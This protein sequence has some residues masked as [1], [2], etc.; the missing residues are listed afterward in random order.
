VL[1]K[2]LLVVLFMIFVG[3][4][5][6]QDYFPLEPGMTRIYRVTQNGTSGEEVLPLIVRTVFAPSIDGKKYVF[7][8]QLEDGTIVHVFKNRESTCPFVE[9]ALNEAERAI[10]KTP[11]RFLANPIMPGSIEARYES[12]L[13]GLQNEGWRGTTVR[14]DV[15]NEKETVTVPAGVFSACVKVK[16]EVEHK[17]LRDKIEETI[18]IVAYDWF[19]PGIGWVKRVGEQ[20]DRQELTGGN[21]VVIYELL[22]FSK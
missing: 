9:Q 6:A 20:T 4:I 10:R 7:P 17:L 3:S 14:I 8:V 5:F 19:A 11:I 2:I 22:S 16:Y 13:I 21:I 12:M 1:K 15:Q 18:L